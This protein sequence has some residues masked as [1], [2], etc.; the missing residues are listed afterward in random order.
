M[1]LMRIFR[2][3]VLP[4]EATVADRFGT[5][6]AAFC[7]AGKRGRG[8][9]ESLIGYGLLRELL[10]E[11]FDPEQLRRDANGRPYPEGLPIDFSISHTEGLVVCALE[12]DV[13]EPRIGVDAEAERGRTTE[14]MEKIAA[15][16]FTEK[17][18]KQ[19][20]KNPTEDCFLKIWT[21]KEAMV[22]FSGAGLGQLRKTDTTAKPVCL[23]DGT[24][25]CLLRKKRGNVRLTLCVRERK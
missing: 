22:K 21:A 5:G 23:P 24:K 10:G 13:E 11:D 3:E 25:V 9:I 20:L 12:K 4:D 17:E 6:T 16:W 15:R 14:E 7:T 19:F 1:V 18:R 8:R 2:Y